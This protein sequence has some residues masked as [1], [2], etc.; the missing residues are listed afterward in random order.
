[1]QAL[2]NFLEQSYT[3]YNACE[4]IQKRLV[5]NGFTRLKEQDEWEISENGK[6]FIERGGSSIIAFVVG[7]LDNFSYK[8]TASHLDSPA[9]KIKANPVE[10]K[11]VVATLN[12]ETYGGG[13]WY[14]FFDRPL[15]IAGRVV[16]SENNRIFSETV[17]SPYLL[18]VPSLSA[19]QNRG[20]N[21][22][23]SVNPQID[24]QPLLSFADNANWLN[25]I[26][27]AESVSAYDLY[28]VSAQSP[29]F[30]GVNDEFLA[31]PRIDNLTSAH[32]SLQ[33]IL[34]FA[35]SDGVCV[36]AFFNAE[37]IGNRTN[38]GADGDFL[39]NTLRR[40]AYALRFDDN[41]YYKALS[42]SF[43]LSVDNAHAVHPNHPE[44]ADTTNKAV[45]GGGVVIK[46]HAGGAY[47]TD[48]TACAVVKTLLDKAGVKHQSFYNRSDMRSGST[49]GASVLA[50]FGVLGADIGLAQLAM[51]SACECL[52]KS[53]YTELVSALTAFYSSDFL[54]EDDGLIIR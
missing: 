14:S 18:T 23:F 33:A 43:L 35:E 22:G 34:E 12:T 3:A 21:D 1:M 31:S 20:V 41:E 26:T 13:I 27:S 6:Y 19:H 10:K 2:L 40:I 49:L 44:K 37:E 28:L 47:I 52:A 9:L 15:K 51:H 30:F 48:A 24:L 46:S 53:D 54:M 11:G 16:K 4:Y 36:S 5:E 8:I 39:E 17:V 38:Q 42:S 45:L 32:A 7:D 50:R 29:Y 25:G